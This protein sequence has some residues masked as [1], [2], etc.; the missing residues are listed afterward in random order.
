MAEG[1][2][3]SALK[4]DLKFPIRYCAV[5]GMILCIYPVSLVPRY[6]LKP[7]YNGGSDVSEL[8]C[9]DCCCCCSTAVCLGEEKRGKCCITEGAVQAFQVS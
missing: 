9:F 6:P 1:A 7:V 4:G 5:L 8:L 3:V 2:R